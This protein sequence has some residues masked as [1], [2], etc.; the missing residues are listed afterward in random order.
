MLI[1]RQGACGP[2]IKAWPVLL[3]MHWTRTKPMSC[4]VGHV[5]KMPNGT[6]VK[7]DTSAVVTMCVGG[8]TRRAP[9]ISMRHE[10]HPHLFANLNEEPLAFC[11]LVYPRCLVLAALS[12]AFPRGCSR[13][14]I[15]H[16]SDKTWINS[17]PHFLGFLPPP[18]LPRQKKFPE[19]RNKS[20]LW[21]S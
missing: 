2:E 14:V 17:L 7:E 8:G 19:L 1:K 20:S 16:V 10:A 6:H 3:N 5:C 13:N 9:C 18:P 21:L 12:N 15:I 11:W 4:P